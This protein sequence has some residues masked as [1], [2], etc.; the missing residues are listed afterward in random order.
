LVLECTKATDELST[1]LSL[2]TE[3]FLFA[4][5]FSKPELDQIRIDKQLDSFDPFLAVRFQQI[6]H[7]RLGFVLVLEQLKQRS[8]TGLIIIFGMYDARF[9]FIILT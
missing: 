5:V 2:L 3:G 8:D 6:P 9:N 1:P 4:I 7:E